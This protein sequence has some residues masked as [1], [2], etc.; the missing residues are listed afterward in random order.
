MTIITP[1]NDGG[2]SVTPPASLEVQ[3]IKKKPGK[4]PV[5]VCKPAGKR[6]LV[7]QDPAEEKRGSI[8]VPQTSQRTF[9]ST[10]GEI[11][12]IGDGY[13]PEDPDWKSWDANV[14][15]TIGDRV[16]W[17][18]YQGDCAALYEVE[19]AWWDSPEEKEQFR[20]RVELV[21]IHVKDILNFH[22]EWE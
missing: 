16:M 17:G 8:Y 13:E 20:G 11:V 12:A 4:L 5:P 15:Y 14:P 9:Q 6:I 21:L 22:Q 7:F 18:R 2:I 10:W 3:M 1:R 19:D